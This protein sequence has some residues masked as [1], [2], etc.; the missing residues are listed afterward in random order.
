MS[1]EPHFN[2][3]IVDVW[4]HCNTAR[5][6]LNAIVEIVRCAD[7]EFGGPPPFKGAAGTESFIESPHDV[8]FT[9]AYDD[10]LD[11]HANAVQYA[12]RTATSAVAAL[13]VLAANT[14]PNPE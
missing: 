4:N 12:V 14:R 6:A 11:A 10:A 1:T 3:R 13:A 9:H 5:Q 8:A 7:A 2:T